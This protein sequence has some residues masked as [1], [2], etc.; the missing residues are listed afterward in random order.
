MNAWSAASAVLLVLGLPPCVWALC[1]GP[2]PARPAGLN[3]A[4]T[5]VTVLLMLSVAFGR[6][7]YADLV[8][9]LAALAPVGIL[10]FT[11]LLGP[12]EDV[13]E[14]IHEGA[15]GDVQGHGGRT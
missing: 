8:L 13:H 2:V 7:S 11:R 6:S 3:L 15:H 5:V 12:H 4:G 1:R 14:D 10:V 9:V